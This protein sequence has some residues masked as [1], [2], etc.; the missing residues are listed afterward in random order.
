LPS[1][2]NSTVILLKNKEE[3]PRKQNLGKKP[4]NKSI[5]RT[6]SRLF[7]AAQKP[8]ISMLREIQII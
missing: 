4:Y 3:H 1:P 6:F 5:N 2:D 8:V 7:K